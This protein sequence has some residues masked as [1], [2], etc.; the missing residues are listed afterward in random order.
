MAV[1]SEKC[2]SVR[3]EFL[4]VQK[5]KRTKNNALKSVLKCKSVYMGMGMMFFYQFAGYNVVS[6][7]AGVILDQGNKS[8]SR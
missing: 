6:A 3:N 5:G 4:N 2:K 7:F 8:E 1:Y